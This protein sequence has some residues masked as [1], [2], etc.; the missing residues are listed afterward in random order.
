MLT[1]SVIIRELGAGIFDQISG[2]IIDRALTTYRTVI[3]GLINDRITEI[4]TTNTHHQPT[5]IAHS[6]DAPTPPPLP[7]GLVTIKEAAAFLRVTRVTVERLIKSGALEGTHVGRKHLIT[8][9]SIDNYL[10][11]S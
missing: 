9:K 8:R 7:D 1:L 11:L 2:H 4:N 5:Q 10:A 6:V 3:T